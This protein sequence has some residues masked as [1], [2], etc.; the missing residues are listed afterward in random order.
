[1]TCPLVVGSG[2]GFHV[3]SPSGP[4]LVALFLYSLKPSLS[5]SVMTKCASAEPIY[6]WS[7]QN[8]VSVMEILP[9]RD[10]DVAIEELGS[11]IMDIQKLGDY[12]IQT[13]GEVSVCLLLTC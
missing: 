5:I 11:L 12:G 1:M 10:A 7:K 9:G 6:I 3:L 13:I 8:M 4:V 2:W